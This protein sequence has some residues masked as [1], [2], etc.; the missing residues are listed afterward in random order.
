VGYEGERYNE[1]ETTSF[2]CLHLRAS[3]AAEV[4]GVEEAGPCNDESKRIDDVEDRR[5]GVVW[6]VQIRRSMLAICLLVRR[7]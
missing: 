1:Y 5:S 3:R 2:D 4:E 6:S 7:D